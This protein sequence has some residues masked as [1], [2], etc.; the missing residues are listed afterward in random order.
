[1]TE[2]LPIDGAQEDP[3]H[4]EAMVAKAEG[5][6]PEPKL[7][8]GKYR[9]EEELHAGLIELI[10]KQHGNP[11]EYYK[12]LESQLGKQKMDTPESA[13]TP[14]GEETPSQDPRQPEQTQIKNVNDILSKASL[15]P[16]KVAEEYTANKALSDDTYAALEKAHG[17]SREVVDAWLAGQEA[18]AEKMNQQVYS[19]AGGEDQYMSMIKWASTNIPQ[20]EAQAFDAILDKGDMAQIVLAVQGLRA[21]Y[22]SAFGRPVS[23]EPKLLQG[24]ASPA[25]SSPG[26]QSRAEIVR[27]MSDPRYK[28]D[29][30]YR[31]EVERRLVRTPKF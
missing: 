10:K 11:E 1:M 23:S 4:I 30:A 7:Y 3:A 9:S 20:A 21:K 14:T 12:N 16:A 18:L 25:V 2:V 22:E 26:Y 17:Y 13:P 29:P 8:A 24:V 15:D 31:L 27:A 6:E 5:R 28:S 19:A